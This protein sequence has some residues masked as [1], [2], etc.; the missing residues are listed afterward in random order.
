MSRK[1]E[2]PERVGVGRYRDGGGGG[3]GGWIGGRK[4]EMRMLN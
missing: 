3:G 2:G 4:A 1:A